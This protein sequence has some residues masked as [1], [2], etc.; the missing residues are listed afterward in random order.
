MKT[1]EER[2]REL[3]D[4]AASPDGRQKVVDLW[5]KYTNQDP[6]HWQPANGWDYPT[7]IREILLHEY[8]RV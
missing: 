5:R 7:M 1:R 8:K 4:L 3:K 2:T 6:G